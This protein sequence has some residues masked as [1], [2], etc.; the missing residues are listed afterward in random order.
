MKAAQLLQALDSHSSVSVAESLT[1]GLLAAAIVD[2]PG[3]SNVFRGGVCTYAI[4]TKTSVLK[5]PAELLEEEGAVNEETA[6]LMAAGVCDL[7]DSQWGISTTGVA[8]PGPQA[9]PRGEI[10]AGTALY[11]VYHQPTGKH[12]V[13]SAVFPGSRQQVRQQVVEAALTLALQAVS[14]QPR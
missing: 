9:G 4:D 12:W 10:A 13:R 3:A 6:I 7:F 14:A 1:G 11:A 8:G 2:V 5:V